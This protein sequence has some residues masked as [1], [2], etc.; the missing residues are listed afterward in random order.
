M[1]LAE[2]S[3]DAGSGGA[4]DDA[5][6]ANGPSSARSALL[7]PVVPRRSLEGRFGRRPDATAVVEPALDPG[8][9]MLRNAAWSRRAQA[10]GPQRRSLMLAVAG[11]SV[12]PM[13][14]GGGQ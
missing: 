11:A 6:L 9:A 7:L 13:W 12:H 3:G 8:A 10:S 2:R 14:N 1:N 4:T 5:A